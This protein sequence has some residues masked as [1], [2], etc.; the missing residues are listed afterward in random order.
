MRPPSGPGTVGSVN[1]Y[2]VMVMGAVILDA[3]LGR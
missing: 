2:A 3:V 1:D